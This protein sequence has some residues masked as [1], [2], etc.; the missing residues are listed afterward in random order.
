[1]TM[2]TIKMLIAV[3]R[4]TTTITTTMTTVLF[5]GFVGPGRDN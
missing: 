3:S 2:I 1:M 4:I 5:E